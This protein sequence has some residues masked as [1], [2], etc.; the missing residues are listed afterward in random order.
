MA[1]R[2][3]ALA[4]QPQTASVQ[5]QL[6]DMEPVLGLV[7]AVS[8]FCALITPEQY[9]AMTTNQVEALGMAQ[10]ILW[11]LSHSRPEVK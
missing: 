11:R 3:D 1:H 7:A 2:D 4:A 10:G 5:V 6:V 8:S 9:Q